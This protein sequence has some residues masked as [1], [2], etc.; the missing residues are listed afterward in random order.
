MQ[1]LLTVFC[2]QLTIFSSQLLP[3]KPLINVDLDCNVKDATTNSR[4]VERMFNNFSNN[5]RLAK[6]KICH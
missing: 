5:K 1:F 2:A 6:V 4:F 3:V